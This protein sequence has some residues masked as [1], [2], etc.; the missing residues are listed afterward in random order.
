MSKFTEWMRI[1]SVEQKKQVAMEANTSLAML[2]HVSSGHKQSSA[3][4]AQRV[5]KA[6]NKSSGENTVTVG[7][8]VPACA[9]CPHFLATC[10]G[11]TVEDL[12]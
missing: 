7:D 1:A 12:V 4:W 6:I 8:L 5:V 10:T 11:A 2:Y 9:S 3:A